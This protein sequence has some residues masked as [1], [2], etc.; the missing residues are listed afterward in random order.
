MW[1][2][3]RIDIAQTGGR[4]A[5]PLRVLVVDDHAADAEEIV[6]ELERG[7]FAP[8]CSLA[9]NEADVLAALA[10]E[11]PDLIVTE[12]ALPELRAEAVLAIR[13]RL[14]LDVPVIVAA[15]EASDEEL[16]DVLRAGAHDALS[17]R[18]LGRLGLV[19]ERELRHAAQRRGCRETERRLRDAENV[20]RSLVEEIP[21]LSYIS[22]ADENR[23]L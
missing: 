9:V 23:S 20:Y 15:R 19:V 3:K 21:A 14:Q 22:W 16:V 13:S 17:K 8:Q 18:G 5:R 6:A 12:R 11:T 7:G 10:A 1:A 4:M 2:E